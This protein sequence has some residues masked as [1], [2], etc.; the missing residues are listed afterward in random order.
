LVARRGVS[1]CARARDWARLGKVER[2]IVELVF[3]YNMVLAEVGRCLEWS[4][5]AHA[6]RK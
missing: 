2:A 1:Q 4:F 3:R 5:L 6:G